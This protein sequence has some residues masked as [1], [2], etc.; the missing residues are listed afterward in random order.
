MVVFVQRQYLGI[1]QQRAGGAQRV[2]VPA[3]TGGLNTRDSESLMEA[4]DAISMINWF[5]GQGS[6]TTRKG[7]TE[8]ATGLTGN[9]ETLAEF[10]AGNARK[11]LCANSDEIN[12]I[13]N[14]LSISNLGSGFSNARW[15][16]ANFNASMLFVN[17]ADTPQIYDGS[18]LSNSTITGSGLTANNLIGIN[19]H[20]NRVY[21]WE[22]ESQSFWFGATN[23]IG[24]TFSEFNLS[25]IST[26][27][28]NLVAMATWNLDGG[29]GVDDY[30][31]FLM[32]SGDAILYQGSD[33]GDAANWSLVG[34]YKIGSPISVRG[35]KKVAGDVAIQTDQGFIFFSQVF[36]SGGIVISRTKLSGAAIEAVQNFRTNYGWEVSF[37]PKASTGSW[38]VFNVPVLTNITYKQFV[39]NTVTG[40]ATE[41]NGLNARTWGNYN[42]DFYFGE[43]GKV[44]KA[45]DGLSD[46]G[47]DI[48]CDT[49]A[50]FSEL[51]S[52]QGKVLNSFRNVI[53]VDGNVVLNTTISFDY[54]QSLVSQDVSTTSLGTQWDVAQWDS[55]QWAPE[56]Q[57]K[58]S[59][60][61]SSGEG[62]ALGM[63]IKTALNGQQIEWFRTDYSVNL[64][65][66]L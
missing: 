7:Y 4:T 46:N 40:A 66:I 61:L 15:Q 16:W 34:I 39:I 9:V 24:G 21:V 18:S 13:T 62:V 25:R 54:G 1:D 57:T 11:F 47:D 64:T 52:P 53:K 19:V 41:F 49:Q 48:V 17:G 60:V 43:S 10:N 51:G 30:A 23:A 38:L 63:R 29:D 8:Y 31:L 56:N 35:I 33:P 32:S 55:F 58:S 36:K 50:A 28:G 37:F 45:D 65:N 42:N 12:D 44:M 26:S 22:D 5:P 6:V 2:N 59:L 27:G 3:P 20:K 14:P